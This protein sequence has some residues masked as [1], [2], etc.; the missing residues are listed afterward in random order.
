MG[1]IPRYIF[2]KYIKYTPQQAP[3]LPQTQQCL[4]VV[5][6]FLDLCITLTIIPYKIKV[7]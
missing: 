5:S 2:R 1:S 7:E 4:E 3:S 6:L